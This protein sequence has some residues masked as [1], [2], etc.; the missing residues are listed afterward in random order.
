[1]R[2]SSK[3]GM[4]YMVARE[5]AGG[6]AGRWKKLPCQAFNFFHDDNGK[7]LE[8]SNVGFGVE[9]PIEIRYSTFRMAIDI[10][11]NKEGIVEILFDS[12]TSDA[13]KLRLVQSCKEYNKMLGWTEKIDIGVSRLLG[14]K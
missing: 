13:G 12:R 9:R 2:S 8:F 10:K 5:S 14:E 6:P 7:I 3:G 11:N 1:M 4:A